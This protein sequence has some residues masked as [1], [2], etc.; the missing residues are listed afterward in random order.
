MIANANE[1]K[2][3]IYLTQESKVNN[4]YIIYIYI[5]NLRTQTIFELKWRI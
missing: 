3:V 4:L 1:E 2:N 5:T